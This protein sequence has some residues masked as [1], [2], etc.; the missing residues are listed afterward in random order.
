MIRKNYIDYLRVLAIIA[1]IIIHV[2]AFYY[3][4]FGKIESIDWW[5]SNLLNSAS[6]FSVPLFVMISGAVLLGRSITVIGFYRKRFV[7]L[8]PAIIFWNLFFIGFSV[9]KGMDISGLIWHLKIGLF[10]DGH[11]AVH[12]WYL[13]M[14]L[15]LMLFAPFINQF[16][17]GDKPSSKDILILLSITFVFFFLNGISSFTR[18]LLNININWFTTF[19]WYIAYFLGGYYL[20]K[21]GSKLHLK[22][23]SLLISIVTLVL[24]GAVFNYLVADSLGII[25]DYFILSNTGPLVFI[26][27]GLIFI[28]VKN[29]TNNIKENIVISK[30]SEA[31]FGMY[32]IHPIFIYIIDELF[33]SYK[34][35]PLVYIPF[36]IILTTLC[37]FIFIYIIRKNN[38]IRKI[39]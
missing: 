19:P 6:R 17:N 8:V 32:L 38:S 18:E 12:L 31:S 11:A 9:Y 13:T 3:N 28:F 15:C 23:S 21:N 24:L 35:I 22:N 34:L 26:I 16:I 20:D 39:C 33:T 30:I 4:S 25:K 5:F 14:F 27:S 29:N 37:S 2:T 10:T 1:V 7:R 36:I